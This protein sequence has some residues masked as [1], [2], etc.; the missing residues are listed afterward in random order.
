PVKLTST[1]WP[2][3]LY[4]SG[5]IDPSSFAL[6]STGTVLTIHFAN[7]DEGLYTLWFS[8]YAFIDLTGTRL[9]GEYKGSFPSG[10]GV[11]GGRFHVDINVDWTTVPFPAPFSEKSPSGS[12][13]FSGTTWG[14][15]SSSA[16]TDAFTF[17]V[18]A[19]QR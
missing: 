6:N 11:E 5:Q 16:D 2:I 1:N 17:P 13:I 18:N 9:D 4:S 7:L 3:Y 12:M 19:G 15:V 8:D 10:N 14:V